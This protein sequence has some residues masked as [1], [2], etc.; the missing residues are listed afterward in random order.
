MTLGEPNAKSLTRRRREK[1]TDHVIQI[2]FQEAHVEYEC[3]ECGESFRATLMVPKDEPSFHNCS[4]WDCDAFLK[5]ID[6]GRD[7][8]R[9]AGQNQS[10]EAFASGAIATDGGSTE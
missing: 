9:S 2:P 6:E 4:N 1:R 5:F 10:L 7:A 8:R 3:P